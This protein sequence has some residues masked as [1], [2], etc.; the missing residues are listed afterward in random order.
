MPAVCRQ[1]ARRSS[2]SFSASIASGIGVTG[3]AEREMTPS[4]AEP[5]GGGTTTDDDDT[6]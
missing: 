4:A 3:V 2:G 6:G 1:R 5:G